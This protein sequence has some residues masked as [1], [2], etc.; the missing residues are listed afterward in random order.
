MYTRDRGVDRGNGSDIDTP[1]LILDLDV[2]RR[3][4]EEVRACFSLLRPRIFYSVKAN[5]S[6]EVLATIA[7][8]NCGFDVA[9][10]GEIRALSQIGVLPDA[11]CFSSTVKIPSHITE[12]YS[13]GVRLFAF[14]NDEELK[15]LSHL[16][17]RASTI[18]RLDVPSAGSR[19]P[20]A[21][22]FG[23]LPT[24]ALELFRRAESLEL[25][26]YGLTFH[27]GSQCV[28]TDSWTNA[29][30]IAYRVWDE[31][32][33][34][35]ISLRMLNIGG[36]LP[37]EYGEEVPSIAE[38]GN[39]V[40]RS[41]LR[42]FGSEIEYAIEPGR[43]IVA[44]AGTLV[45]SVIGKARR[46]GNTWIYVDLSIYAGLLEVI[47]AWTYPMRTAKDHLPKHLVTLAGPS[48]DSTDI[49]ASQ[50]ALP[51]LEVGDRIELRTAGAYTTAYS[52][53]NGLEFPAV[54]CRDAKSSAPLSLS[55][56][57]LTDS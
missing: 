5:P 52:N 47:G 9:S 38:I 8:M 29:L 41:V 6:P 17:P 45:T 11:M 4:V 55:L 34:H 32:E 10:I 23:A 7:D 49:I 22:K 57:S 15:K 19:W 46:K 12:A 13:R 16:A 2:I 1:H 31:A 42:T 36:G 51:E 18:L 20:L 37:A 53:Y 44:N 43:Y 21:G 48:C 26:A 35:G 25:A 30:E 28:R 33:R 56:A 27:V 40:S 3:K 24:S 14:D 50:I 54:I 39:A